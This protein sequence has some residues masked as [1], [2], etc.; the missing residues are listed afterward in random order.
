MLDEIIF[1]PP[2]VIEME[3]TSFH[4]SWES[5]NSDHMDVIEEG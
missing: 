4:H 5:N 1:T 2:E 3:V